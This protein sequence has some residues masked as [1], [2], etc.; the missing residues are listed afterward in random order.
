MVFWDDFPIIGKVLRI[1]QLYNTK[2]ANMSQ[3]KII[4]DKI[5]WLKRNDKQ[6]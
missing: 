4:L 3:T 1:Y 6:V 5:A 2:T